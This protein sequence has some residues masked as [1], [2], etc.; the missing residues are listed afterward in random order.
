M[1]KKVDSRIR[2][3][4]QDAVTHNHRALILLVGD[5]GRDQVVN[6]HYILSKMTLQA[7]PPVLWMYKKELGFSSN[8]KKRMKVIK[9]RIKQGLVDPNKDDPFELFISSTSIRFA[10]YNESHKILGNTYGMCVLQDFEALTP[11]LLARTFETVQGG[12]LIVLLIQKMSS[13]KQLYSLTMDVHSRLRTEAHRNVVGRFNERFILSLSDCPAAIVADDELNV[14]PISSH[15]RSLSGQTEVDDALQRPG[16]T[17]NSTGLK[18]LKESLADTPP[19]GALLA[20]TKTV[21]QAKAL[22]RFEEAISDKALRSTVA[23]TASRGRGKS[24]ALGLAVAAAIAHEYSNIFVTAPSPENLRTFFE[25][26]LTG[27]KALQYEEHVDYECIRSTDPSLNKS[28]VRVNV[29]R[30]HRQTVQYLDPTKAPQSLTQA[31][32]LVIDEAAAIPLP[33]VEAMLGPYVVFMCSTVTGYEGTGRSLSLKLIKKLREGSTGVKSGDNLFDGYSNKQRDRDVSALASTTGAGRVFREVQMETPIRYSEKDP[34]EAWLYDLLCLEAGGIRQV[35]TAGAPHP[36]ECELYYVERDA[37]FSRHQASETFL[38]RIMAL[39]VSSHYKNS[40]NDLQML[41]DAPAHALFVLLAPTRSDTEKLPDVLCAIQMCL[42]G[43]I[44]SKSSKSSLSRG[45]RAA[46]DL[47]PW[48]I[49]QQYQEADFATLSG[50]RIVRVATHADVQKMGYGTRAIQLLMD[51]YAGKHISLEEEPESELQQDES[52]KGTGQKSDKQDHKEDDLL[53]ETIGPRENI[54]PLLL[55][56]SE[57]PAER[58]DYLGVS[59]GL[60]HPLYNFWSK[61]GFLPLYIR[62]TANDLTGEHTCIMATCKVSET[63]LE[64]SHW[65]PTFHQDFRRRFVYLL[66]YEFSKMPSGLAMTILNVRPGFWEGSDGQQAAKTIG[67]V[68]SMFTPYD[69]RRLESYSRNLVDYHVVVDMVP[70]LAE[71]YVMGGF[72]PTDNF[73]LSAAQCA[74]L[75]AIGL[76]RKSVDTL[77][78]EL[79]IQASQILALFNKVMRKISTYLRELEESSM[80]DKIGPENSKEVAAS[81]LPKASMEKTMDEEL[82]EDTVKKAGVPRSMEKYKIEGNEEEWARVLKNKAASHGGVVS[83]KTKRK[84]ADIPQEMLKVQSGNDPGAKKKRRR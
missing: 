84:A 82:E 5:K 12:G 21:D 53:K 23:L 4:L 10:Y 50:A 77:E 31:E 76:Q 69:R 38:H 48:T 83:I 32:L 54:P 58:L 6:L 67:D 72:G 26:V 68:K 49:S 7:R 11:N 13:L 33:L 28:I 60:T 24:A 40:P 52:D 35:L 36:D 1:K 75:V 41:S 61:Q 3:T 66:G 57:R 17:T 39:F 80:A 25:F 46:G 63:E 79:G 51:Y 2:Q 30:N 8:R 27:F 62:L 47:I 29:F 64:G 65:L 14:L 42:E 73:R 15:V 22:L 20:K 59:F 43:R 78:V 19:I 16:S 9:K 55:R 74:I 70:R 44:S 34:I 81:I 45:H 71:M 18:D 56:L 37:L